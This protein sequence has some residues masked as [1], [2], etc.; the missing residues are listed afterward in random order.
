[1]SEPGHQSL[2]TVKDYRRLPAVSASRRCFYGAHPDHFGDLFLPATPG[3]HRVLVLIH[4]GCWRA[5]YG[6][7]PLSQ[8]AQAI[9]DRGVAVWSIEYRRLGEGGGW[10]ETFHDAGAALD[11]LRILA[12]DHPLDIHHVVTAGHS[13]GGHLALWLAARARLPAHSPLYVPEPLPVSGVVSL[14]GIPDLVVAAEQK[15]CDSNVEELI[16]GP[17]ALYRERYADASPAALTPLGVPHIHIHGR[18]DAIVPVELVAQYVATAVHAGD[19]ATMEV[20]PNVGHFELVDARTTAGR[21]VVEV[22]VRL[23]S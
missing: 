5:E 21:R 15:V 11:H 23:S 4:G 10:P 12:G 9:A 13:A 3:P 2:L 7:E 20:L 8:L 22:C 19:Y 1:L 17:P 16:G 18:E 6:L 14:A